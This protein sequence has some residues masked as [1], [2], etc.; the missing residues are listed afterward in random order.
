MA[1]RAKAKKLA[2]KGATPKQIRNQTGVTPKAARNLVKR[3]SPPAQVAPATTSTQSSTPVNTAP[4]SQPSTTASRPRSTPTNAGYNPMGSPARSS[5]GGSARASNPAS[6]QQINKGNSLSKNLRIAATGRGVLSE[7]ELLKIS[8]ASG[9]S[10]ERVLEKAVGKG[11]GIGSKVVNR[12]QKGKYSPRGL[13][14]ARM[15]LPEFAM[16][17]G[18]DSAILRQLRNA[19]RL[20]K[21]SALFI[22]SKGSTATVL[23]R[24]GPFGG[25]LQPVAPLP[26]S[27]EPVNPDDAISTIEDN[28][29]LM[30][31]DLLPEEF[32]DEMATDFPA[33]LPA[34]SP[35]DSGVGMM[36]GGGAGAAGAAG[37]RSPKSRLKILGLYGRG[38]GLLGRGLQYGNA[39]NK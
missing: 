3:Y 1:N 30:P 33:Q 28:P 10:K 24:T 25:G 26:Q 37:L 11:L 32:V 27:T 29:E 2:S 16:A 21:G 8:R 39:L 17:A 18:K 36:A 35:A 15:A 7:K 31:T 22:G 5:G 9:K 19:G 20:D 34:D 14:L 13:A 23:P 12:Y 38:T 4:R 6:V